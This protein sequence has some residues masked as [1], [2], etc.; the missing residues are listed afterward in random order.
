MSIIP[1]GKP[2]LPPMD[3]RKIAAAKGVTIPQDGKVAVLAIRDYYLDSIGRVGKGDRNTYDDAAWII[4]SDRCVPFNFSSDPS[5]YRRGM[6]SLVPGVW[7]MIAGKHKIASPKGYPAFRQH[8]NVTVFRDDDRE[9][10]GYFGINLH[11]GGFNGTSSEGCQTVPPLQWNEFR[12]T[13]QKA[14]GTNDKESMAKPGGVPGTGFDYILVT[15]AEAE[16]II[17]RK[18]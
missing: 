17:G 14:L 8:G 16:K 7:R 4:L 5:A 13:L 18:I 15:K 10:T 6:A 12:T 2:K 11:R 1:K 3:V 9:H